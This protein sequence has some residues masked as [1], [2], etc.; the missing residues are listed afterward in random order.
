MIYFCYF[1]FSFLAIR[2]LVSLVNYLSFHSFSNKSDLKNNKLVSILIPARNEEGNIGRLLQQLNDFS[3]MDFEVIVYDDNSD[4]NTVNVVS[5]FSEKNRKFRLVEGGKLSEGWLGKNHACHQLSQLAKGEVLLFLDADVRVKDGLIE[6]SLEYMELN[7]LH[8]LS[9]FPKQIFESI[10][11]KISVPLMNWILLSLLP[12]FLIRQT[13]NPAFAAANGQF[14]M[15]QANTYQ[16]YL[17]H[18]HFRM[19][20]VEDIAI[21]KFFKKLGLQS[22][23]LLGIKY[24]ECKMY[25]SASESIDGFAKNIFTFFGNSATITILFAIVLTTAPIVI[26]AQQGVV[27]GIGYLIGIIL[28]RIFVSLASKQSSIQNVLF[29]FP[30]HIVFLLIITNRLIIS[31]KKKLRWKGRIIS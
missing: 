1:L 27:I 4:D 6:R 20:A 15:F 26:F 18:K 8:L 30:Q 13:R 22:D 25:S 14:M 21:I 3:Y 5:N 11:E 24:I 7:K 17:P 31:K 19:N 29:L 10:G 9:I 12:L 23:M 28:I 2:L 16:K